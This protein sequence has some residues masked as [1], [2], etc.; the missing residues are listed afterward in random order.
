MLR[1]KTL[2]IAWIL[3]L[4]PTLLV[5]ALALRSVMFEQQRIAQQE[6][7]SARERLRAVAVN[8]ELTVRDMR[9]GLLESL[10]GIPQDERIEQLDRWRFENPL[11]RNVFVWRAGE[12][13]VFPD[14][15]RPASD[16]ERGFIQRYAALF[17]E[18]LPWEQPIQDPGFSS[19]GESAYLNAR[20][21]LRELSKA[22]APELE[23]QANLA[24]LRWQRGWRTWFWENR[25]YLLG[26]VASTDSR[27][28]YGLEVEMMALLSR[29]IESLPEVVGADTFALLDDRGEI[30]FQRGEEQLSVQS[31]YLALPVGQ[32]LP[33][34]QVALYRSGSV[35]GDGGSLVLFGTLLVAAFVAAILFG[36]G[37][38]LWEVRRHRQDALRKTTFVSNVSHELKTPLTTIRMYSELMQENL[39]EDER[40]QRYLDVIEN[41]CQR[42]T[43]LVNNVLDF[44]RIEQGRKSYQQQRCDLNQLVRE[45]L[46]RQQGRFDEAQMQIEMS[47][48]DGPLVVMTDPDALEQT[49]LNL[50]DN[51]LKYAA[52]GKYLQVRVGYHEGIP[53]IQV[54]DRGGGIPAEQHEK[55]FEKFHRVDDSLTARHPGSG[56]GLTISRQ[57]MRD[58]GGELR[59][60]AAARGGCFE[61]VMPDGGEQYES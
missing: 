27:V 43:R 60:R 34:W 42:L 5:G 15:E 31:P 25:L 44:G 14:P 19:A 54:C 3:L 12:G 30:F 48:G 16:E 58:Q 10:A 8:L 23:S 50:F 1:S 21:E 13:L 9:E 7:E 2:I 52:E 11:I 37:V 46:A 33:H 26:W 24:A 45:V 32:G 51:A 28:R 40:S 39:P 36:G 47:L 49:L 41:E 18:R 35:S 59:Y 4:V 20:A 53:I 56:L 17:Q 29:L 6:T 38:M 22:P 57:L 61:I 55:I